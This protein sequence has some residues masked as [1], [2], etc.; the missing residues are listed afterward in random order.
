MDR[1]FLAVR[2]FSTYRVRLILD[3]N[4]KVGNHASKTISTKFNLCKEEVSRLHILGRS[5]FGM[6]FLDVG[7]R[8][9]ELTYLLGVTT[10]MKFDQSFYETTEVH[11]KKNMYI[12]GWILK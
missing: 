12:L 3:I 5:G 6:K 7:A 4:K 1:L 8:D 10:N 2:E 9:G 11:S